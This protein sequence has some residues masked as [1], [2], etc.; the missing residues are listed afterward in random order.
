MT[1]EQF[2]KNVRVDIR[3][4]GEN[5]GELTVIF[6]LCASAQFDR[7]DSKYAANAERV[8][9]DR[10]W[11]ELYGCRLERYHELLDQLS[12]CEP[13]DPGKQREII[14]QLHAVAPL[15]PREEL[16]EAR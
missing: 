15:A 14:E 9:R 1:R 3:R 10:L 6:G 7:S 5:L 12:R 8:L 16:E 4:L 11:H 2:D 13:W